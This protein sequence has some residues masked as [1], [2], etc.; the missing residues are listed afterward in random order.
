MRVTGDEV[1]NDG[2]V[3]GHASHLHVNLASLLSGRFVSLTMAARRPLLNF[4]HGA[5]SFSAYNH[6]EVSESW[7]TCWGPYS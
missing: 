2:N 7:G 3:P 6:G 1:I 5:V 4:A